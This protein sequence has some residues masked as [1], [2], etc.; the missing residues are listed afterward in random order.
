MRVAILESIVMP[1]G[2]EVEFDR[3]LV[4]ELYKQG[5]EPIMFVPEKFPFKV[6]YDAK[7]TYLDGGEAISYAG[8][9][10]LKK[11]YLSLLREK[12]RRAWF[13]SMAAKANHGMCDSIIIPT[14]SWRVLHSIKHSHLV[15]SK[16]P[17]LVMLHGIMPKDRKRLIKGVRSLQPFNNIHIGALGLQT[18]FPEL[19]GYPNF[20]TILPPIYKP[21]DL[22][23]D[24]NFQVHQPLRLGFFGQYRK[25]KNLEFFLDAF[26]NCQFTIPVT[27]LIQGATVTQDDAND[28]KRLMEKY[29]HNRTMSF[30]HKNLLGIEWQQ[31]LIESDVLLLPYGASRYR[32][33][34]SAM[35]F[36]SIGYYKP[37]LQSPEMNPEILK[38]FT[39]GEAVDLSSKEA[40]GKQLEKFVNNFN[41][42]K[43]LYRVGLIGANQKYSQ[44]NLI[45]KI[46]SI[47]E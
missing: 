7:V 11:I 38:E 9:G 16:I 39:I 20:H 14:A 37:V 17:V 33:Q 1:A 27:L 6:T 5:H 8:V 40:F 26:E 22:D 12:R 13:N 42:N 25:E 4:D 31:A 23:V 10:R 24:L 47:L 45:K 34:P 46:C 19:E 30:L 44:A 15:T 35:L 28:F 43:E 36:T 29:K 3:I 32:Y 18:D 21:M 2:H 41:S